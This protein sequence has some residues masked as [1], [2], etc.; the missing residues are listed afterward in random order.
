MCGRYSLSTPGDIVAELFGLTDLPDLVPR[1]NIAPTQQSAVVRAD[2]GGA[3]RLDLLRWGLVPGWAKDAAIGARMINAR[4]E[5]AAE[6]PSFR[7][8]LRRRRC[9][10]LAD[11][12]YEWQRTPDG[13]VPTRVQRRDGAPFAL[14]GLW[15][16]W[17]RGP[18]PEPLETFT[19]LTTA[20]NALLR[21]IHDRMPVILGRQDH[22]LWLD[23]SV[24]EPAAVRE[25]LAPCPPNDFEAFAVSRHVNSP[26]HDDPDCAAPV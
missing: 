10:V 18:G 5:T 20:P 4:S 6:K 15:E 25:L 22:A 16:R 7:T 17:T 2:E 8:A 3:R 13:K 9:L 24:T 26:R 23:S 14:A 12:F 1:W 21:P 11:G 19:I